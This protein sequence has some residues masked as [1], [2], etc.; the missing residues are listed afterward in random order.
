LKIDKTIEM[1]QKECDF[2]NVKIV[3]FIFDKLESERSLFWIQVARTISNR[4]CFEV[5]IADKL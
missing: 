1:I 2:D 5:E 3:K 4:L